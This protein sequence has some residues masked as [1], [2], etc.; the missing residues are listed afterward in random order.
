V[1][2]SAG[3]RIGLPSFS[4]VMPTHQRR[5]TLRDTLQALAGV[6]YPPDRMELVLV[7]DGCTDGSA[8]MA[9]SLR[10]PFPTLILEGGLP[11]QGPAAARNLALAHARGPFVLFLDDDVLPSPDLVVEHARAH[12]EAPREERVVVGALLPPEGLRTPW[13]QWE[14]DT[15]V[16]QYA[17]MEAGAYRPSPRQFYTGNASVRLEHVRAAG[18]FDVGFRRGEDVELAFR[19]QANG[20]QFIF[21]RH[22]AAL[23]M[24]DR[25]FASWFRAAYHYGRNDVVLG[26][27]RGRPDMLR[28][29]ARE[30]WER[31]PLN[32]C[33]V[34][35]MLLAPGCERA[36]APVAILAARLA[37]KLGR[38]GLSHSICSALFT[39]AYWHGIS[40][41]LAAP[42]HAR[43]LIELGARW[44]EVDWAAVPE[45]FR[46]SH[47]SAA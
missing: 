22:A 31:N 21:K 47:G 26:V 15:V 42:A 39:L 20:L 6:R 3:V 36:T 38:R 8:A 45:T 40:D 33:L 12:V 37:M 4:V 19:L 17:E 27:R 44:N 28:A 11:N 13:V 35:G 46:P 29:I 43:K 41:E 9:H 23:H 32:R 25:S 18:G 10:M 2:D 16:R 34:S 24:A 7:C 5:E 14:L 1:S 30:F